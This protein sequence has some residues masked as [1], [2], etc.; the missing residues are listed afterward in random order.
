MKIFVVGIN[1]RT[2]PVEIREK[3]SFIESEQVTV[4]EKALEVDGNMECVIISTCNR[5]EVYLHADGRFKD[6]EIE[7]ILCDL[8]GLD[9]A[10]MKKYFYAY[11]GYSAVKHLFKVVAGLDSMVI[12]EDQILGQAKSAHSLAR[13][14][15]AS[16]VYLNTL[17]RDAITA[18]KRAKTD[19][20]L[21]KC[22]ISTGTLAI[23]GAEG[24]FGG[25]LNGLTAMVIGSTGDI[26]SNVLK[27][28]AQKGLKKL[29]AAVRLHRSGAEVQVFTSGTSLIDYD[30]RYDVFDECD[31]IVSATSSPHYTITKD[32]LQKSIVTSRKRFFIDLAVPRD[33]DSDV[34][35]IENCR[36]INIDDINN[37]SCD[38][39]AR[40]MEEGERALA[41]L[42][43]YIEHFEKWYVFKTSFGSIRD[44]EAICSAMVKRSSANLA[45]TSGGSAPDKMEDI[46]S[47]MAILVN[48]VIEK[49]SYAV[50]DNS[51]KDELKTFFKCLENVSNGGMK[52]E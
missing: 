9:H 33:I 39:I 26:G 15:K 16:G 40:R 31:I 11:S 51:T 46:D 30:D 41:I 34:A 5:T 14:H 42:E 43:K 12:G 52:N 21:S 23:K 50:R 19:T 48:D 45:N 7:A 13:D 37:I 18:A 29:Y 32:V 27:T 3:L 8:K 2:S 4:M 47:A 1:F 49:I 25:S 6:D 20:E 44:V 22:P 28:L 10:A 24:E 17:F 36:Y 35:D 38:N